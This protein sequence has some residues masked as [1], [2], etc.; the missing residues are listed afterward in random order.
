M[1]FVEYKRPESVDEAYGLLNEVKHGVV[2]GGG[3]YI[4]LHKSE[5]RIGIDLSNTGLDYIQLEEG[6]NCLRIGAMT[7]LRTLEIDQRTLSIFSGLVGRIAGV[8]IRNIATLGGSVCGRYPF[9]DII[10]MLQV[11]DARLKFYK[12]GEIL[13]DDY[14]SG[15]IGKDILEEIIIPNVEKKVVF[16]CFKLTYNDFSVVNVAVAK[17]DKI[18]IAIGARPGKSQLV[19]C[20]NKAVNA[21]KEIDLVVDELVSR[22]EFGQD[23][24]AGKDYRKALAKELLKEALMEVV[25]WK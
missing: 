20:E 7:T 12:N 17:G 15:D 10:P 13:L 2:I 3:A 8:P 1:R 24:R 11:L 4:R 5:T 18:V 19:S 25:L 16:K 9:S 23:F 21:N 22:F 6:S 14:M